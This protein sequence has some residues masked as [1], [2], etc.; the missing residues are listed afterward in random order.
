MTKREFVAA[1]SQQSGMSRM[2][3]A[4]V[5]D[6][7]FAEIQ[8]Q[9]AKGETVVIT[10]FGTFSIKHR[11]PREGVNPRTGEAVMIPAHKAPAFKAGKALKDA[12]SGK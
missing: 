10:G 12:V 5:L 4:T 1:V 2:N 7:A 9:L 3:V 8:T 11:A 6:S